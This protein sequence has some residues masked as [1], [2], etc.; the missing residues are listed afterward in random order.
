MNDNII[1]IELSYFLDK[2]KNVESIP[3]NIRIR[4]MN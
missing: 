1:K 4:L 2:Y 3:V